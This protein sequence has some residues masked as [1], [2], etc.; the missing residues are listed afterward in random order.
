[1][2]GLTIT[3]I[4][5]GDRG[6]YRAHVDGSDHIGRLTW[7]KKGDVRVAEHTLVPKQI[8]G[9][10]IAYELVKIMIEDAR[11][12]GFRIDPHCPYVAM[13]F[14]KHPEWSGLRA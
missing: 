2:D 9:R 1:M 3:N 14:D 6:E 5:H 12:K 13:R 11:A 4:D 10:G 8:G 7:V